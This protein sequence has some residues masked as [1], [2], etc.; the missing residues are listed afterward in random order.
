MNLYVVL[1]ALGADGITADGHHRTRSSRR[2][3]RPELHGPP[4]HL[5]R[6]AVRRA[7]RDVLAP[8][9]P[10]PDAGRRPH[11]DRRLDRRR[12]DLPAADRRGEHLPRVPP[13]RPR[14]R[15]RRRVARP[16]PGA[17]LPLVGRRQLRPRGHGHVRGVRL[18]RVP[19]DR[20]PGAADPRA[21]RPRSTSWP[22]PRWPARWSSP[23]SSP[24]CSA[25]LVYGL[26]FRPLR[27]A[28]ALA[29]VVASLGLL[30]YLQEIV[31]LRFPV[32]GA[33]VQVNRR[34]CC[35][36]TRC[37]LLGTTVT[38]NRLHPRRARRRGHR[39]C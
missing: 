1:R 22:A 15:R 28:P 26:V 4:L 38:Q 39:S 37:E 8:A 32:A 16:R 34:R 18:L 7:A 6:R 25:S 20:R 2:G 9:D 11:P 13:R 24:R 29:R 31:R 5:R 35:P 19:R 3:G 30:L 23:S 36:T 14:R 12:R 21:A 17:H 33:G 10:R 27:Q